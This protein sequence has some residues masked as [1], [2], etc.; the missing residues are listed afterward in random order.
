MRRAAGAAVPPA[1]AN[2]SATP[3]PTTSWT[4]NP[5]TIGTGDKSSTRN[6]AAVASAAVAIVASAAA[7]AWTW[8]A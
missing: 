4:P 5:R 3:I 6:P 1:I 2:S 8:I 7:R